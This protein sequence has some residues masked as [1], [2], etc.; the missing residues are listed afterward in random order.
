MLRESLQRK[1][2]VLRFS[3]VVSRV[4]ELV[5]IVMFALPVS[6][7]SVLVTDPVE[8]RVNRHYRTLS[9]SWTALPN[10]NEWRRSR[11]WL[12]DRWSMAE[13]KDRRKPRRVVGNSL[14]RFVT[15]SVVGN[16][17]NYH[18]NRRLKT[19][20]VVSRTYEW[21][22]LQVQT[23]KRCL[24]VHVRHNTSLRCCVAVSG[25]ILCG[26]IVQVYVQREKDSRNARIMQ[27]PMVT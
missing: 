3:S 9:C 13:R 16:G 10:S 1:S 21:K 18:S 19:R 17:E 23:T 20:G 7:K 5:G 22:S 6:P 26:Y 11:F 12:E 25:W 4:A 24:L 14:N 2:H 27:S 15:R 8:M